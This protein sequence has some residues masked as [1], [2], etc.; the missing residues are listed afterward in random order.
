VVVELAITV[1]V[2]V[3]AGL[4]A[5]SFYR[6]LHEDIGLFAHHLAVLHVFKMG[7]PAAPAII[8]LERQVIAGIS[9]LP[10]V[11][12]AGV[13]SQLAV[14][15]GEAYV[16]FFNYFRVVGRPYLGGGDEA[17]SGARALGT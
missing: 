13:S 1:V 16:A 9:E 15:G 6:L 3:S 8:A 10:G 11:T 2:L 14:A 7:S 17:T 5:K 4:L 12:S